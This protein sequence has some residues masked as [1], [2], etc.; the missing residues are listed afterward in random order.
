MDDVS[1]WSPA[2]AALPEPGLFPGAR[3]GL[4]S[5]SSASPGWK[6]LD[7]P[8][9]PSSLG[10]HVGTAGWHFDDWAGRFYP[11]RPRRSMQSSMHVTPGGASPRDWFPF[12]QLYFSFL[13]LNHTFYQE[14]ML[15]QF[16]ELERRS[17][18][19]MRFSVKVHR[20]VSH[21][22][23]WDPEEGK[24]MMRRHAEAAAPL[25]EAGRLYSFLIQL[26]DRVERRRNVL[27][28]L[29]SSASEAVSRGCDV[30]LELRNRTWHQEPVL[31]ALQDAGI[32][33]CNPEIPALPHVF[34][35]RAYATSAKG[36][37]RYCGLNAAA[38]SEGN[39]AAS[40]RERL[41]AVE[42]RYDYLYSA[43]ELEERAREQI[44]L[45]R[46][47]GE[48]AVVF[49]NHARAQAAVNAAQSVGVLLRL[50]KGRKPPGG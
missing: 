2:S 9:D 12:Y 43:A 26:D 42:A 27:D 41:R 23:T 37:V 39:E 7:I 29:L 38:W 4:P 14:P 3:Q 17:K 21:K 50:L 25:A 34:P 15:R 45:L 28:Y 6:P 46:K 10:L 36:Y 44:I 11:P 47:T 31:R 48:V 5:G 18:P 22:G 35:R 30:H 49:K 8:P 33:I 20:N 19:G 40:P 1:D 32:G 13:E 16:L 24:S